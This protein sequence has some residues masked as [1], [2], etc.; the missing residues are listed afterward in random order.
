MLKTRVTGSAQMPRSAGP[1]AAVCASARN[2][3]TVGPSTPTT[4]A[5]ASTN[6]PP[7]TPIATCIRRPGL[8]GSSNCPAMLAVTTIPKI[9]MIQVSDAAAGRRGGAVRVASNASNDVPA[10]PTPRP[11]IA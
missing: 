4:A 1:K 11:I 5:H 10:A 7:A 9:I 3:T 2:C 8:N 6:A